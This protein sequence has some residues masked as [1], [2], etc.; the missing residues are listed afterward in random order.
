MGTPAQPQIDTDA[1]APEIH[2]RR[3]SA[4]FGTAFGLLLFVACFVPWV[5]VD[6]AQA[7][8]VQKAIAVEIAGVSEP[9]RATKDFAEVFGTLGETS[10]LSGVDLFQWCRAARGYRAN[11][12]AGETA[13]RADLS[14]Q[15]DR[16]LVLFAIVLAAIPIGGVLLALYFLL[17]GFRRNRSPALILAALIGLTAIAMAGAYERTISPIHEAVQPGTGFPLLLIGGAGFVLVATF[18]VTKRNWWRVYLG[19]GVVGAGLALAAYSYLM[20]GSVS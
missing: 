4:V 5:K 19:V 12:R 3:L 11:I 20:R 17:N 18:G 15:V 8:R 10:S 1:P 7:E 16:A 9:T 2:R 14:P 13:Q 6:S